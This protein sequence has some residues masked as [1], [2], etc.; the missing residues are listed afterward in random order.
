M[1]TW[2]TRGVV[3]ADLAAKLPDS[4]RRSLPD[5]GAAR[6][7]DDADHQGLGRRD[8][9]HK[10]SRPRRHRQ[11]QRSASGCHDRTT[12]QGA[13]IARPAR[14]LSWSWLGLA[15]FFAF[16]ILFIGLPVSYLI[17]GSFQGLDGQPTLQNYADLWSPSIANA[18]LTSVE[19]SLVTAVVGGIFGFLLAYAVI[20]G[21]L[22]RVHP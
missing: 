20:L 10:S 1:T 16:A 19:V 8:R 17:L 12:G 14:R 11:D 18:F 6:S 5:A 22:P 7:R 2:S 9:R 3:P 21:G 13:L 4:S 15:P